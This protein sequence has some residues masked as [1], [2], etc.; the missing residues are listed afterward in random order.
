MSRDEALEILKK[1]AY[2]PSIINDDFKYIATKLNISK[3]QLT[4]YM[5]LPKKYYWDY[6]NQDSIFRLG[7]KI[8]RFIGG[9]TVKKRNK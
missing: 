8:L 1:P 4:K 3:D 9:E 5:E 2:D 6:K 7:A